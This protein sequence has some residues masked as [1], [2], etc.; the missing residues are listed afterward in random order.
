[1]HHGPL[2][3]S[4]LALPVSLRTRRP[5]VR[6]S[7]I[8]SIVVAAAPSIF[9]N[10]IPPPRSH[11][12]RWREPRS[13]SGFSSAC[14]TPYLPPGSR[15][16][17]PTRPPFALKAS[18]PPAPNPPIRTG[19]VSRANI[20]SEGCLLRFCRM[21]KSFALRKSSYSPRLFLYVDLIRRRKTS[22]CRLTKPFRVNPSRPTS[23][24][25]PFALGPLSTGPLPNR[26]ES[27]DPKFQSQPK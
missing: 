2:R 26:A 14:A 20:M 3:D 22:L 1:M 5:V 16:L 4:S 13:R 27:A 11:H 15:H 8:Q 19:S 6:H 21:K 9:P 23:R 17:R 24:H 10:S 18:R 12:R 25:A 7:L